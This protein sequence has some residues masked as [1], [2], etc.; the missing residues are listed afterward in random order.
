MSESRIKSRRLLATAII[1]TAGILIWSLYNRQ[2][3]LSAR[4]VP[5]YVFTYAENQS[6]GYPTA[7]GAQYFADLVYEQTDGRI[8]I[9]VYTMLNWETNLQFGNSSD[10]A[11]LILPV[12]LLWQW[13]M[14]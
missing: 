11:E 3:G 8:K 4:P 10:T 1:I 5:E 12:Y 13:Q 9:N 2:S 6:S 7:M 14:R